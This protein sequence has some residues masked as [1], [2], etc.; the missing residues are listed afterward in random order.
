MKRSSLYGIA[1]DIGGTKTAAARFKAGV[2]E[3]YFSTPTN[4][5]ASIADHVG[6]IARILDRLD[7]VKG[8][9][10][11][12][13]VSGRLTSQGKWKAVNSKTL[14]NLGDNSL[15]E[16]LKRA[17]GRVRLSNDAHATT[18]AEYR[19]GAGAGVGNF[20]YLTVSTGVG[21]GL[22]VN[23]QL[24]Q[25]PSGLASHPG[26]VTAQS[27]TKICGSGRVGTV[28]SIASGTAIGAQSQ[29]SGHTGDTR[30]IFKAANAGQDWANAILNTSAQ[31][32]SSLCSDIAALV[33]PD[34]IAIGGGIG[35][36][37]GYIDRVKAFQNLEPDLFRTN[38][39]PATL[40]RYGPLLGAL[41]IGQEGT[42]R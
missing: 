25:S 17:F 5:S 2:P 10:V 27:A 21:G 28:E 12:V 32:I 1:I 39:V 7:W 22:V 35:L 9:P 16:E 38:I 36:A 4:G 37:D 11:G 24:V 18:W 33:N 19:L 3:G 8:E 30:M 13:T 40:G 6:S 15:R 26:F 29:T 41:M 20:C 34:C 14:S 31:A 42:A 23:G